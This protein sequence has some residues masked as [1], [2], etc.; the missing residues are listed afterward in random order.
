MFKTHKHNQ[1]KSGYEE[2]YISSKKAGNIICITN[3]KNR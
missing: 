2:K 3:E 1:L